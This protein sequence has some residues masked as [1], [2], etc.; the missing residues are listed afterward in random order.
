MESCQNCPALKKSIFCNQHNSGP[1]DYPIQ[2]RQLYLKKGQSL[3]TQNATLNGIYCI[4]KGNIK[5]VKSNNNGNETILRIA[6]A[7]DI[8]GEDILLENNEFDKTGIAISDAVVCYIDKKSFSKLINNRNIGL[9]LLKKTLDVLKKA[10][11]HICS[12][13]QKKVIE[14]LSELLLDF[15]KNVGSYENEKWKIDLNLNREEL[16]MLIGT[17]PETAIRA[18]SELKKMGIISGQKIVY[19]LKEKELISMA[20]NN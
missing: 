11:E 10:E 15:K 20:K 5:V 19:I 12:C 4:K 1:G 14:R 7:G 8:I 9:N 13:H 6:N 17:A 16:A 18:F 2:K 3:F